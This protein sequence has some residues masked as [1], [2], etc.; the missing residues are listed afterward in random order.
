[1]L[2]NVIYEIRRRG[3]WPIAAIALIVTVGAPLFFLRS[4]PPDAPEASSAPAAPAA[5]RLPARAERL[6]ARSDGAAARRPARRSGK[7][8]PFQPPASRGASGGGEAK[9]S[10]GGAPRSAPSPKRPAP[11]TT[12]GAPVPV[13]ITN[14][15]R[16][17]PR[18]PASPI[19]DGESA[20]R[21]V[22][23]PAVD[24]RYGERWPTKLHRAIPRNQ[25]FLAGGRVIAV[26][27]K[28]SPKRDKAVF[29]IAPATL[30][31]GDVECRRKQGLCRYVDVPAGEHVGL[32]TLGRDGRPVRRRIDVT[33][34]ERG[35]EPASSTPSAPPKH[36]P[37]LLG[38]MLALKELS[39]PPVADACT[40]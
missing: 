12:P 15:D 28:Y 9:P 29:A 3:L 11:S 39:L 1:M 33:R 26:F 34:I 19:G 23:A 7:V 8:D 5:G 31:T 6:L 30:V 14:P 4:A 22:S 37:C 17:R 2:R 38:K 18:T 27:V 10:G 13:V 36:G 20:P 35:G 16:T 40:N 32:T 25:T 21:P 24:V